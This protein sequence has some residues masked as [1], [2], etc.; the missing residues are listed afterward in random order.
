MN[1]L[2]LHD[3]RPKFVAAHGDSDE[4]GGWR[5]TKATGGVVIDVDSG[6]TV[7]R[8]FAM[9]HH[10][11]CHDGRL[12]VL[13][14]GAG[15]LGTIELDTGKLEPVASFP[16]FIRR[17]PTSRRHHDSTAHVGRFS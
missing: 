6:E 12:W 13:N 16:G 9:P 15:Q 10:L 7:A 5:A 14:S 11:D 8:G 17:K 2:A 3:G 1:G 4:P